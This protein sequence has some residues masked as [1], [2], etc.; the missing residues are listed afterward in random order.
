MVEF[1]ISKPLQTQTE[2]DADGTVIKA[3][4]LIPR[5]RNS[6]EEIPSAAK[7]WLNFMTKGDWP[8]LETRSQRAEQK[9]SK[10]LDLMSFRRLQLG[11]QN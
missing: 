7:H 2:S 3:D 11:F 5:G 9:A 6:E 8:R 1:K 10:K 4:A